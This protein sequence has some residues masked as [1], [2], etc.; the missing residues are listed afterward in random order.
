MNSSSSFT[1]GRYH[2]S[3]LTCF[4]RR[5]AVTGNAYIASI[6]SKKAAAAAVFGHQ[7]NTPP[8]AVSQVEQV[9]ACQC[10]E[11]TEITR[12]QVFY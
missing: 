4:R 2:R 1:A 7:K 3:I 5:P 6:P 9:R 12:E 11:Y 10:T 8:Q